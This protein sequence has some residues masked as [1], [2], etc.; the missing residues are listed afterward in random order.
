MRERIE[1]QLAREDALSVRDLRVDGRDVMEALGLS[2][3]PAVGEVLEAL[4]E[5]VLETPELNERERLL[6]WVRE[7]RIERN[8]GGN[9]T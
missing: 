6:A 5:R 2:P 4:L 9:E 3:G 1:R 7:S 8:A